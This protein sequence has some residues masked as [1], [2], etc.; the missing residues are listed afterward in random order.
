[1]ALVASSVLVSVK[2]M[3]APMEGMF[4]YR[5]VQGSHV[6]DNVYKMSEIVASTATQQIRL[7]GGTQWHWRHIFKGRAPKT[8]EVS[9]RDRCAA[10]HREV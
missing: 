3:Y 4:R 9:A 7:G 2:Y 5:E 8:V 6:R 1:M 10:G